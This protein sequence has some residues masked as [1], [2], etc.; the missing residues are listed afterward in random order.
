M[1][2]RWRF[3]RFLQGA[4]MEDGEN[5][6]KRKLNGYMAETFKILMVESCTKSGKSFIFFFFAKKNHLLTFYPG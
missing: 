5:G 3:E 6:A 1:L 4:K 2:T